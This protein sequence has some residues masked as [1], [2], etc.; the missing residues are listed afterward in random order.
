M[1]TNNVEKEFYLS[2]YRGIVI[3]ITR[4]GANTPKVLSVEGK[5]EVRKM[6]RVMKYTY[7]RILQASGNENTHLVKKATFA[8]LN[9]IRHAKI[10]P[11]ERGRTGVPSIY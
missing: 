6:F 10:K 5:K 1:K 8:Y 7:L 9:N 4:G 11:N 2:L 3:K